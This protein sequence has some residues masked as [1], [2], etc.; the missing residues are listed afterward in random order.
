M[1]VHD[2]SIM[3]N[4]P[5]LAERM[6]PE[7]PDDFIGQQH[8][9]DQG[10]PLQAV[11]KDDSLL[12]SM[13]LWG[14]PGT[15]KTSFAH[16]LS[17]SAKRK[18]FALSASDTG[19]KSVRE[20]LEIARDMINTHQPSPILFLDEIHR[21]SK[22]QQDSLL[23]GV[24]KGIISLVGATT[25]NPSF[26][27]NKALLSRCRV[28]RFEEPG[29]E[30]LIELLEKVIKKDPH[31]SNQNIVLKETDFILRYSGGDI[32]R[33]LNALEAVSQFSEKGKNG[34][35]EISNENCMLV[36][37]EHFPAYDKD[38]DQHYDL[39][40]AM[41]KS[42]RGSDPDAA[43]Y[44][45]FRMLH[46]GEDPVF[47]CRRLIISASED[48]GLANPNALLLA[49]ACLDAVRNIGLPECEITM[50]QCVIYLASSPKSNSAY[51]ARN[52]AKR[53]VRETHEYQVPLH[54]RNVTSKMV[55]DLGYGKDYLYPHDYKDNFVKQHY[56]PKELKD[57]KLY[58]AADNSAEAKMKERLEKWWN[59][60]GK[61]SK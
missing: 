33:L 61:K 39:V 51:V 18:F 53:L 1:S 8:L 22:S 23:S 24:E 15:G 60:E 21:F 37:Q 32:R 14:P 12:H 29:K 47:I 55:K 43:L 10:K 48:I 30:D 17:K 11:L 52:K 41:I 49:T 54:L 28:Y 31:L 7:N 35:I 56:L 59:K 36:L 13:I 26:E 45:M 5:P 19:I 40:S 2:Q 4:L 27:I 44:Y 38:G 20:I 57:L 46:G 9:F 25:E 42:I 58:D 16:L 50:S 6:R 3:S 34:E